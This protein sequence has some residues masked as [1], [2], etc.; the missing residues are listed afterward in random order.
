MS[1]EAPPRAARV[2][3]FPNG[4]LGIVWEDGHESYY[5]GHLL[6]CACNCAH[7]VEE[8]SGV[9]ILDDS[10]VPQD[11]KIVQEDTPQVRVLQCRDGAHERRFARAVGT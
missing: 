8:T 1:D 10:S 2:T 6:R 11:V 7:C 3:P 4:E 9:K 5:P